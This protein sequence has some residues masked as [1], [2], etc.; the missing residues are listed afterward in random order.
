MLTKKASYNHPTEKYKTFSIPT[1]NTFLA[2]WL[3]QTMYMSKKHCGQKTSHESTRRKFAT[4]SIFATRFTTLKRLHFL[5]NLHRE[6][7][8]KNAFPV[9]YGK[10]MRDHIY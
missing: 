10:V 5:E 7:A 6:N 8:Y 9:K 3:Q 1:E 4:T 2:K